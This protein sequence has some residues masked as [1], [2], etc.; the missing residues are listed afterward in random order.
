MT[1]LYRWTVYCALCNKSQ[2]DTLTTNNL[3]IINLGQNRPQIWEMPNFLTLKLF[4]NKFF[5][6]RPNTFENCTR[7]E[8]YS[9]CS[10]CLRSLECPT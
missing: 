5:I 9:E 1:I 4:A 6:F 7:A 3:G 2:K 10:V 8:E